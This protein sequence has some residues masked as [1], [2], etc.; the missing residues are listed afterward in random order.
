MLPYRDENNTTIAYA[1]NPQPS[2]STQ[3]QPTTPGYC[4]YVTNLERSYDS[5]AEPLIRPA[6]PSSIYSTAVA[7]PAGAQGLTEEE[8]QNFTATGR[9]MPAFKQSALASLGGGGAAFTMPQLLPKRYTDDSIIPAIVTG[10]IPS[11]TQPVEQKRRGS[12]MGKLRGKKEDKKAEEG[13]VKVIYM[14]R[15]DYIKNFKRDEKNEYCGTEPYRR[16][17]EEELEESFGK[18]KPAPPVNMRKKSK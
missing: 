13:F 16:W 5:D 9:P 14:P 3:T 6:S 18:Y 1:Q 4:E 2:S 10:V 11:I 17:T 8:T 12:I 15:R 7:K